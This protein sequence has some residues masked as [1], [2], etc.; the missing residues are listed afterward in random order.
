M[1]DT[2]RMFFLAKAAC[3]APAPSEVVILPETEFPGSPAETNIPIETP[4]SAPPTDGATAKVT[5]NGTEYPCTI[6]YLN[7]NGTNGYVLGN[8]DA[9][10]MT[11]SGSNPNAPFVILLI[12]DGME[13]EVYGFIIPLEDVDSINLSIVQTEGDSADSESADT[14]HV[15]I[16]STD[17]VYT[18]DKPFAAVLAAVLANKP[19]EF[20]L[21]AGEMFEYRLHL[22]G[23]Q[24][25]TAGG[26]VV[27]INLHK[28]AGGAVVPYAFMADETIAV[29]AD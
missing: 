19:V 7:D 4:L 10:G 17:G 23:V 29:G 12:P 14:M 6:V 16:T 2:A 27:I 26:N 11:Y 18:A 15:Y 24:R 9:I 28:F 5:Y 21:N 25:Q 13:G 20:H 1:S 8:F 3:S 22:S